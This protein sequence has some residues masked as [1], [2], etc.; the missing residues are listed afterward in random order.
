M[1]KKVFKPIRH[2][3]SKWT[4]YDNPLYDRLSEQ[5]HKTF[6]TIGGDRTP[7]IKTETIWKNY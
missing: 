5:F 4:F 7:K 3:G 6:T 2:F 1:P